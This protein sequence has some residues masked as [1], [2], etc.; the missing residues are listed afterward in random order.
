MSTYRVTWRH[1]VEFEA[2]NDEAAKDLWEE[3]DLGYLDW[4]NQGPIGHAFIEK[5]SFECTSDDYREVK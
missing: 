3:L 5:I 2:A 4:S 1:E